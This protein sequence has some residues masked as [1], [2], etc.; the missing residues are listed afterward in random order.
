MDGHSCGRDGREV[1]LQTLLDEEF[2][3]LLVFFFLKFQGI[4]LSGPPEGSVYLFIE[5]N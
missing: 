1:R 3:N 5:K 4:E 2:L